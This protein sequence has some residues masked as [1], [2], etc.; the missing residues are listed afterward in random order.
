MSL[1]RALT[2]GFRVRNAYMREALAEFL[3]T[4]VLV[5]L[6]CA[7]NAQSAL[8]KEA[9]GTFLSVGLA[10]GLAIMLGVFVCGGISGGH[11]NP[12]VSVAMALLGKFPWRKVPLYMI[13]QYLGAFV[14]SALVFFV[15][16]S[17]L[18]D[19]S[20]GNYTIATAGIFGTFPKDFLTVGNG[21]A[22]QVTGAA[23]LVVCVCAITD[24]KNMGT[25]K[26]VI[27]LMVGLIVAVIGMSYGYNCGFAINPARDLGPRLFTAVAGWGIQ[28]FSYNDY[29]WWWIPVVGPHV[30]AILGALIYWVFI[31][32]HW[33]DDD[34]DDV[35]PTVE[36]MDLRKVVE[37]Q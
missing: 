26:G 4:F 5:T 14:G 19:F 32:L 12:A 10:W 29:S 11:I 1:L 36:I 3:G 22:D 24:S 9:A 27:P 21:I 2:R 8:S 35:T 33:P 31:E 34:D 37:K 7:A 25:P 6:G 18:N 20:G 28:V 30:G 13:G 16:Q 23:I 17:A 15:Y